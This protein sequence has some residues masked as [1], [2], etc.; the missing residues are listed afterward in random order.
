MANDEVAA[1]IPMLRPDEVLRRNEPHRWDLSTHCGVAF[2]SYRINDTW[3]RTAE[4]A[5]Q[6]WMP[7]EWGPINGTPSVPVVLEL[8]GAGDELTATYAGRSVIYAPTE[9]TEEDLCA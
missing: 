3:W 8:S 9:L 4:G 6:S 1:T 5:G 2:F 7:K